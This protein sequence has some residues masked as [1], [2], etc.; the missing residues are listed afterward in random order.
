MDVWNHRSANSNRKCS[1]ETGRVV[2]FVADSIKKDAMFYAL[3]QSRS[4]LRTRTHSQC[5]TTTKPTSESYRNGVC[6]CFFLVFPITL[7]SFFHSQF[8][9][10][11]WG[12]FPQFFI[13]I[14]WR[15]SCFFT[16]VSMYTCYAFSNFE[17]VLMFSTFLFIWCVLKMWC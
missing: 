2:L 4:C 16:A 15:Y 6:V 5:L 3:Y 11:I 14:F 10:N 8:Y 9:S 13:E 12:F 1:M 17:R 7:Y